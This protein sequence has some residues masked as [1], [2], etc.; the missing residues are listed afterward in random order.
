MTPSTIVAR[1]IPFIHIR[2]FTYLIFS[3]GIG[4]CIYTAIVIWIPGTI[5][6]KGLFALAI[7]AINGGGCVVYNIV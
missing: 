6:L 7:I 5:K 3:L 4:I 1:T 2:L